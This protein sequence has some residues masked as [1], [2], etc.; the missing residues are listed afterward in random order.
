[1]AV[2]ISFTVGTSTMT[3]TVS[4]FCT[5]DF[6]QYIPAPM[7]VAICTN[8]SCEGARTPRVAAKPDDTPT[9]PKAFPVKQKYLVS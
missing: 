6:L 2:L 8:D 7:Q 5:L 3:L 4:Q 1:M 9:I